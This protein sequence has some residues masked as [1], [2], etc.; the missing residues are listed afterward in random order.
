MN[1]QAP[2]VGRILTMI[3]FAGSCIGLLIF[4]WISFGGATPFA[5]QG[6]LIKAEFNQATELG[7][8]ADVRISGVSV[9]KVVSVGLDRRTGLTRAVMR[10]SSQYVPRPA[11]TRAILRAKTLLGETYIEL[12]PG[13]RHG[14]TLADGGTIPRTQI[15]S[16]VQLDQ[17]LSTFDPKTRHAFQIWLQQGGR[18]ITNR[19]ESLNEALAELYPFAT[20]VDSV[21][22]VLRR[23]TAAT[24][25]LLKDTG[26]VFSALGAAPAQL[27]GFIRNSNAT[28]AATAAR[29]VAL[30][31]TVRAFPPYLIQTRR[32]VNRLASFTHLAKPLIDELRPAAVQLSPAL[33][34]LVPVAPELRNLMVDLGPLTRAA[35]TGVPALE[36]F[37][38]SAVPLLHRIRPYLG[39]VIPVI[40]YINDF[41]REVAGFFA[42]S[43]ADTQ[44]TT[45][46]ANGIKRHNV[47]ISNPVN[48]EVLAPYRNRPSSN[49]AAPY[50]DPGGYG[51]LAR[52]LNVFG[53]YVC[54][55][56][57]QPTIGSSIPAKLAKVLSKVYFTAKPGGPPC[58]AQAPLGR[59]T[60][61]QMKLFPH[62]TQLP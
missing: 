11:D 15:G 34:E 6:Y 41:R 29:D 8:Q 12:T 4:L 60:V 38:K 27:Q 5:G 1:K 23:D 10:I 61:G 45:I 48:P 19:G 50:M 13:S 24:R 21:L 56:H 47:R 35:R 30:A 44:N 26:T 42:N 25:A 33:K 52:G 2:S 51:A 36:N 54:T 14:P 57:P 46:S 39:G 7:T 59:V 16:S 31:D 17:I 40:D 3:A 20:N 37:L 28:F 53:G 9:G 32:T 18:A 22:S 58:R 43:A 55:D 49:R 62:L